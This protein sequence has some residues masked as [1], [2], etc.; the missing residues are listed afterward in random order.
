MTRQNVSRPIVVLLLT[1]AE[2]ELVRSAIERMP[3]SMGA[4]HPQI[5]DAVLSMLASAWFTERELGELS[6]MGDQR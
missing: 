4:G 6:R 2:A 5:R 1:P 3:Q